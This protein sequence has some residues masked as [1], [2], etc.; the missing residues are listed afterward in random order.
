MAK[1]GLKELAKSDWHKKVRG[2][3]P[4][5]INAVLSLIKNQFGYL[6][7]D[8]IAS[9]QI[10]K[11][12]YRLCGKRKRTELIKVPA[13]V[14]FVVAMLQLAGFEANVHESGR[15]FYAGRLKRAA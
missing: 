15:I 2:I 14:E 10:E 13:T 4:H 9:V 11:L 12:N 6:T 1:K 8:Q 7:L 5:N 3:F